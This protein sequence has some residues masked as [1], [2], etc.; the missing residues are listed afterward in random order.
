[1]AFRLAVSQLKV[2]IKMLWLKARK[3]WLAPQRK[4]VHD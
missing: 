2:L 1:M 3:Q 4:S